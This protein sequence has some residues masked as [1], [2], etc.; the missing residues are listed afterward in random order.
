MTEQQLGTVPDRQLAALDLGSNSFH[1]IVVHEHNGHVRVVDKYKEMVRLAD[2]LADDGDLNPEVEQ[3]ALDCLERLG[4]RLRP[5]EHE[6]VRVV[7]TNALRQAK[8]AQAFIKAAEARLGHE[9]EIISGREE[10]RLIYLGVSHNL[11]DSHDR[12]LVVDIGGGSTELIVGR[13]F[14]ALE[15]E[16]LHMGCVSMSAQWIPQGALKGSA[17]DKA[18]N[19]ARLELEPVVRQF[20]RSQWETAVGASG[21]IVAIQQITNAS[22]DRQGIITRDGLNELCEQ[23]KSVKH[24][25]EL[26]LPHLAGERRPVFAGGV[27]ILKAIFDELDVEEMHTSGGALREGLIQDLL[28]RVHRHDIREATVTDLKV[29]YHINE[30]HSDRV[31]ELAIALHAQV[32]SAWSLTDAEQLMLLRWGADLHEIGMDISHSQYH[33][34]GSYLLE[35]MDMPGFSLLDQKRLALLVRAHRRK[36]PL[37]LFEGSDS[38]WL[39]LAVLLRISVVLRRART[40][41]HLPHIELQ[42]DGDKL[43]LRVPKSWLDKHPLTRLDLAQEHQYLQVIPFALEVEEI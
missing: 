6:N 32:A 30:R 43:T 34:H 19:A 15:M 10:A 1:L 24:I 4:E 16:S 29:R 3:R 37:D 17:F 22:S 25:M 13:H 9:L 27:A 21:T 41:Q 26:D 2:G 11:E 36:V 20:D 18:V 42:A 12:R 5:L 38:A 28:G 7:G 8:N 40:S 33:K 23:L 35:H 39:R 14:E 31:R